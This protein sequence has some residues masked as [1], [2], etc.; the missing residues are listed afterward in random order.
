MSFLDNYAEVDKLRSISSGS[1]DFIEDN[2]FR[3][4]I[5]DDIVVRNVIGEGTI[6]LDL[7][8]E[9]FELHLYDRTTDQLVISRAIPFS[10]G[11]LYVREGAPDGILRL[12]LTFWS[13]D[14]E[15]KILTSEERAQTFLE[16]YLADVPDGEYNCFVHF[17][18]DELGT[19]NRDEWQVKAISDSRTEMILESNPNDEEP[20]DTVQYRQF[21]KKSIFGQDFEAII[22]LLFE[23]TDGQ[24]YERLIR[25]FESRLILLQDDLYEDTQDQADTAL[26]AVFK[27]IVSKIKQY[28][29]NERQEKRFRIIR[30]DFL[31]VLQTIVYET[32]RENLYRFPAPGI[33]YTVD[34]RGD[35][36]GGD[37]DP[38]PP[39]PRSD[40]DDNQ[41][42]P[43]D[44]VITE[45]TDILPSDD[46][47]SSGGS[48]SGGGGGTLDP[49]QTRLI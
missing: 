12:G 34:I 6:G 14:T 33:S 10:E 8:R 44:D 43:T 2:L 18:G 5:P 1:L 47:T 36:P 31:S 15:D 35:L 45:T 49:D 24:N 11:Y 32:V 20:F 23:A 13:G 7:D 40:P 25:D 39:P 22:D 27:Q 29:E 16:R 21:V 19:Y 41:G 17:F 37:T 38:P 46:S 9:F 4:A 28:I 48:T 42:V 30:D 3:F 26:R